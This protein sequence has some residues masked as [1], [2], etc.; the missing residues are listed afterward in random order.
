M[1]VVRFPERSG[2]VVYLGFGRRTVGEFGSEGNERFLL[3][4]RCRVAAIEGVSQWKVSCLL[5]GRK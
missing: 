5:E 2:A 1:W 3:I 4:G